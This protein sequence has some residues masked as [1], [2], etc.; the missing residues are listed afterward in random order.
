MPFDVGAQK[1]DGSTLDTY[2]MIVAAFS[3]TDKANRVRFFEETFLV[4]N[5]SPEVVLGMP[6]LTLSGADVDFLDRELRWRSYTTQEALPTTRCI[7]LVG[8]KEF[9]AAALDPEHETY[10][11]YVGLVSSV[12]SPSSSPLDVH[13]SRRPQIAGLIAEEAP[14][15]VPVKYAD[16]AD[17]FS[18]DLASELPEHTEINNHSIELVDA[19]GFI[20]PSKSPAGAPIFFDRKSD[21]SLR[22]CV[23]YRGLNNLTIKN[24]YPLP[25]VGESLDRKIEAVY[26]A[27]LYQCIPSDENSRKGTNG[28]RR[29]GFGMATSSTK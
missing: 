18:P 19:N 21:G 16:F 4:A 8:K 7:K 23:D 9:S 14:I 10:V 20:R 3:V 28:R 27:R 13:P 25:L 5:V 17:V 2:G 6:F 1:I 12:A 22:L 29:S 15:K 11:V 26:P 24:R